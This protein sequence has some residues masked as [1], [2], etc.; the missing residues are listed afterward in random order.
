[1]IKQRAW[2]SLGSNHERHFQIRRALD[3]LHA[4]FGSLKISEVYETEPVGIA[5]RSCA[6]FYNLMVGLM[7]EATPTQLQCFFKTLEANTRYQLPADR[8]IYIRALDLDLISWGRFNGDYPLDNAN[9]L[10]LP[11]PQLFK[12]DF[13]LRP[14]AELAPDE[15]P[16]GY[17]QTYA[18][19]W[20][21]YAHP[22][23]KMHAVSFSALPVSI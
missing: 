13:V 23:Q 1:M 9:I 16:P 3:A 4:T 5:V 21:Q 2:V 10:R 11:S 12:H 15:C 18:Q 14:L 8:S 6:P 7:T 17:T 19:L 20:A 22:E